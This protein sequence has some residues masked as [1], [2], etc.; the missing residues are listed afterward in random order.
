MP[1]ESEKDEGLIQNASVGHEETDQ[2]RRASAS[3]TSSSMRVDAIQ[4]YENKKKGMILPFEPH[5]ITFDEVKYSVDMPQVI[6]E[7]KN[8]I[9]P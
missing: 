8:K 9:V 3:S 2:S 5:S 1:E 4:A 7:V 6:R